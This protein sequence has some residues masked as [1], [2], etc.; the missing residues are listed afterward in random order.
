M[1]GW[2]LVVVVGGWFGFVEVV[3]LKDFAFVGDLWKLNIL[4]G[5][6]KRI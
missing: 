6:K 1:W 4:G 3:A 5:L 2:C